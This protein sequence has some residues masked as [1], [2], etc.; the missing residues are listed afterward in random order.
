MFGFFRKRS[1]PAM[2]PGVEQI[3]PRI[4]HRNFELML[5]KAGVPDYQRPFTLRFVA[6]LVVT[7]AFD[8]PGMFRMVTPADLERLRLPV[9]ELRE[10]ALSNLQRE[11]P[12]IGMRQGQHVFQVVTGNDLEACVL[13]A[14]ELWEEW[15]HAFPGGIVA[16]VP[17]R[18]VLV[19]CDGQS[20]DGIAAL[21]ETIGHVFQKETN[22]A[23]T[24]SLL[25]W[26]NRRW[27][28][29]HPAR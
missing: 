26:T 11:I 7:Y 19:V 10:V 13:L 23:L 1:S 28:E 9:E 14:D 12:D 4:K 21:K 2:G 24:K 15:A 16:A 20:A 18:D 3:V 25:Q 17:S 5:E 8:V 29:F 22:H 6:D 27:R